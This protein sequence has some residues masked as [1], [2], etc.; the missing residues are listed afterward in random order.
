MSKP[1]KASPET[2]DA[3][4]AP[5]ARKAVGSKTAKA[6]VET[7]DE[8]PDEATVAKP[9]A[10]KAALKPATS[11]SDPALEKRLS[12][13]TDFQLRAYQGSNAR[14]SRDTKHA[15]NAAATSTLVLIEKEIARRVASP[16]TAPSATRASVASPKTGKKRNS[17]D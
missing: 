11:A 7:P 10:P 9:A 13:M 3:K 1:P 2:S 12:E 16:G 17:D 15:K 8:A 4:A 6:I 14:I 5:K